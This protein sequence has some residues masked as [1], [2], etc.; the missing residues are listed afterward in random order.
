[1]CLE[2]LHADDPD[3]LGSGP[4][5]GRVV[6]LACGHKFHRACIVRWWS[7]RQRPVC[8]LPCPS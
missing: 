2:P 4:P 6:A 7:V 8:V 5:A 1:V 3:G